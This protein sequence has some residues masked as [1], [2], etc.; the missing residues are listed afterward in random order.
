[1]K[2]LF[3]SV[4]GSVPTIS[5]AAAVV[6]TMFF[7]GCGEDKI[8]Y[9]GPQGS[10]PQGTDGG[11]E[12][13]TATEASVPVLTPKAE[14]ERYLSCVNQ[15]DPGGGGAAVA[16]YGDASPCWKGSSADAQQCGDAC[17]TARVRIANGGTKAPACG[18]TTDGECAKSFCSASGACASEE[19]GAALNECKAVQ[20]QALA[21]PPGELPPVACWAVEALGCDAIKTLQ[22][23]GNSAKDSTGTSVYETRLRA[24]YKCGLAPG[25]TLQFAGSADPKTLPAD[26]PAACKSGTGYVPVLRIGCN[27]SERSPDLLDLHTK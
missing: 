25:A 1:M 7:T 11:A 15:D 3:R 14:C 18:C 17:R 4:A 16:L 12:D 27:E 21:P 19:W 24:I 5:C 22:L 20:A 26:A 23:E 2:S 10:G 9:V 6:L 8:V 13:A